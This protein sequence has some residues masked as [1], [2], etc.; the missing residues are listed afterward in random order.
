MKKVSIVLPT[1]NGARYLSASID[2]CLKQTYPN[3]ELVIVDDCSTDATPSILD[4]Y[5]NDPRVKIIRHTMNSKLPSALNTGF[6]HSSGAY[7]S[8]TSDDNLYISDAIEQMVDYLEG[9]PDVAFVYADYWLI[10]DHGDI[11]RRVRAGPPEHLREYCAIACFLYRRDVY[12]KVG[13][14]DPALFRYEDYDYWLRVM[15]SFKMAWYPEPLYF[16]RRHISSL[17]ANDQLENRARMFDDLQARFF[18][19]DPGRCTRTLAQY[20][21]AEA[22]ERYVRRDRLGVLYYAARA[23]RRDASLLKNRGVLSIV[24][25]SIVGNTAMS[26]LR[27]LSRRTLPPMNPDPRR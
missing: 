18:G 20:Y 6:S 23:I 1:Y 16:Y 10:D 14:Y 5:R 19:A 21:I 2:S 3:I 26:G 22:F 11:M 8:W 17:T 27:W 13:D 24:A 15:Q 9:H 25:E 4:G 12:D 7:L